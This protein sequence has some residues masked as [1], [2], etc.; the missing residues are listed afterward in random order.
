MLE[1]SSKA[2][3]HY[4]ILVENA[5]SLCSHTAQKPKNIIESLL[6]TRIRYAGKQLESQK[7]YRIIVDSA[8]S[9]CS[10]GLESPKMITKMIPK[11]GQVTKAGFALLLNTNVKTKT[12]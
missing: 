8:N 5:S 7:H 11:R 1:N 2:K 4:R 12:T 9:L 10:Q 3:Q 6:K